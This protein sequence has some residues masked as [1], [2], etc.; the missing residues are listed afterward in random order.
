MFGIYVVWFKY[1]DKPFIIMPKWKK[2]A[3]EFTVG[4]NYNEIRGYQCSIPK[5]IMEVLGKPDSITFTIES[6]NV[7]VTSQKFTNNPSK[8][9]ILIHK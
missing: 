4:V 8:Q 3:T 2:D 6:E 7:S 5:P 1:P 9:K